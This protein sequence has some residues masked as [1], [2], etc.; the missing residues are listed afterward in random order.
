MIIYKATNLINNKS[1]IGQTINILD[2]RKREHISAA[3]LNLDTM[4]FHKAI[5]KYGKENFKWEVLCKCKNI[6][7]LNKMERYYIKEHNT[8]MNNGKGYNMTTGGEGY[9]LS[10][11]AIKNRSGKNHHRYGKVGLVG[12]K[13]PMY[14][15]T[16]KDHPFYGKKHSKETIKNKMS[17][18]NNHMYGKKR[19]KIKCPHCNKTGGDN[20]MKRWHFDN[21]KN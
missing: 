9:V 2:I 4:I 19:K 18:K 13:N 21:C 20:I 10:E 17:G 11:E 16:G 14:G 3:K 8:F 1:Y 15:K 12:E 5:C 6:D 7:E